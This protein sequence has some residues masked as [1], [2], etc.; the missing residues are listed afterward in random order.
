VIRRSVV[1]RVRRTA[2]GD[3][4]ERLARVKARTPEVPDPLGPELISFFKRSVQRRQGKLEKL[5]DVWSQLVPELINDHCA[6]EG[7]TRG[8][9][10]VLVDTASHLY[11][12]K[13]L[14]LSGL[15]NQL[16][17]ACKSTGLRKVALKRGRWY[18]G[19]ESAD[20]KVR[21]A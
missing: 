6:L 16:L 17:T 20:R 11:E 13:Q 1:A 21:F 9:L 7:F 2:I 8:T 3:E 15:E 18:E 12:L 5:A 19:E 4:L 14:L 10:T